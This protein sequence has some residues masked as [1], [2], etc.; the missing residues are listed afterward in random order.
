M[1]CARLLLSVRGQDES[2]GGYAG[3]GG[4]EHVLDV[5]NLVDRRTAQLP[6]RLRDAVHAVQVGLA[7]LAAVGVERQPPAELDRAVGDEVL[8]LAALAE[9]ELLELLQDERR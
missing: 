2:A 7:E 6:D 9:A 1:R 5:G 3:A 8:R 4:D